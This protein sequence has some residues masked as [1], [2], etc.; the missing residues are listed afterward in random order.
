[1]EYYGLA[2]LDTCRD[3][4]YTCRNGQCIAADDVCNFKNDCADGSDE[5][6]AACGTVSRRYKPIL[7]MAVVR[8][9]SVIIMFATRPQ[10]LN[11]SSA[12]ISITVYTC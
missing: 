8:C 3:D 9:M 1:M 2:V 6:S 7:P 5:D 10:Y 4:Q 12:P 11:M